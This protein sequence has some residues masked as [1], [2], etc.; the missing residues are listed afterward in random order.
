MSTPGDGRPL[1]IT[2][3]PVPDL[4]TD[5]VGF[6]ATVYGFTIHIAQLVSA[7]PGYEGKAPSRLVARVH[8]SP[9]HAKVMALL[10]MKN[11]AAYEDQLGKI[12]LPEQLLTDLGLTEAE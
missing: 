8:M 4:Y 5:S 3:G 7:P 9:Q 11:I 12:E 1:I 10:F 6:E 2:E